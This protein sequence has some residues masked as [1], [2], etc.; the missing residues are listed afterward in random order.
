MSD[1]QQDYFPAAVG[2]A[3]VPQL[4]EP[5]PVFVVGM[6]GSGT[7]MLLDCLDSHPNLFGFKRETRLLPYL[8]ASL[9]KYGDLRRDD[10]FR[11]FWQAVVNIPAIRLVNGGHAPELPP[12][13]RER[14][15]SAAGVIDGVFSDF[16]RRAGKRRWCEKT[17]MHALHIR[18]FAELFPQARF[19]HIVRDGRACAHSFQ[20][21]WGYTPER[22]MYR[23]KKVV[24][25]ARAQGREIGDRYLE[26]RF[27][28]M[29]A[30][31]RRWMHAVCAFLSEPFVEEVLAPSRQRGSTGS[32]D[33]RIVPRSPAWKE[34][35]HAA[36]LRRLERIGG[37]TLELLQYPTECPDGDHDPMWLLR[38]FWLYQDYVREGVRTAS[39]RDWASRM[40]SAIKQRLTTRY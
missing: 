8:I 5:A 20:R 31:P 27:E 3:A 12:D 10:N 2:V 16:A 30:D 23:W 7:T 1:I 19:I 13:W 40:V 28:D 6:N 33:T 24:Q 35:F 26:V 9:P 39:R 4:V 32:T 18:R 14:E 25:E 34:E 22:T 36:R 29:T 38:K 21:R 15:R 37:R 17:P 11:R